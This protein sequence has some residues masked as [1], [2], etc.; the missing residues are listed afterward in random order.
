MT[1]SRFGT[2]DEQGGPATAARI[3]SYVR[4]LVRFQTQALSATRVPT[5]LLTT[6]VLAWLIDWFDEGAQ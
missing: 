6:G 5:F 1:I 2:R 3:G 4:T